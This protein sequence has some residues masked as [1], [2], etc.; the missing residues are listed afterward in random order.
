MRKVLISERGE[1]TAQ[2]LG[3]RPVGVPLFVHKSVASLRRPGDQAQQRAPWPGRNGKFG[4]L[5]NKL[6]VCASVTTQHPSVSTK[7]AKLA[8][9]L[10][11]YFGLSS[12]PL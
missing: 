11:F 2:H 4:D 1:P 7:N 6:S 10:F 12:I 8:V 5:A 9:G 3:A